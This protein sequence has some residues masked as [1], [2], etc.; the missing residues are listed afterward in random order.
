M[1]GGVGV[2]AVTQDEVVERVVAALSD[3]RGGQIVTPNVDICRAIRR[4]PD[5]L[6]LVRDA[7]I[8]VADGMPLV[9]ASRLLGT[10]LPERVTGA[11]LIWTLCAAAARHGFPV[12]LLGGGPPGVPERAAAALRAACP[13]LRVAGATAPPYGFERSATEVRRIRESLVAA[14]PRLVFV[15]LGF[16]KQERLIAALREDLPGTWFAGCGSA[17]AFAAGA[18][19]RA[20]PWLGRAGLEWLFRLLCEPGRLARRYLIDDLPFAG[21]LLLR[22]LAVRVAARAPKLRWRSGAGC[23]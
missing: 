5:L 9:W 15:G 8:V 16:P 6:A 21:A 23:G 18:V 13:G 7:E 19:R 12:Y 14:A 22:C 10:P 4:D 2:D 3:G 11:D 17:I 1:V 20:P